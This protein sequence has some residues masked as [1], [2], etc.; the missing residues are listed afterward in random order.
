MLRERTNLVLGRGEVYFDRFN[1]GM[2]S[3]NGE[4]YI[5]NTPSF[6]ITRE[7]QRQSRARSYL[8]KRHEARGVVISETIEIRMTTD[9]MSIENVDMWYSAESQSEN[10]G[11]E[12]VPFTESFPIWRGRYYQLGTS[13]V[14]GGVR[15]VDSLA[16]SVGGTPLVAGADYSFSRDTGRIYIHPSAAITD[17]VT[18]TASYMKRPST[19]GVFSS[20]PQELYGAMRYVGKEVYGPRVDYWFPQVRISPRGAVEMKGDEFRQMSFDVTAIR[21]GPQHALMYG[22]HDGLPPM[23]VTADTVLITADTTQYTADNDRWNREDA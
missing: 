8:G 6:Q 18:A 17:G 9:N 12:F 3:G 11:D 4:R 20:V 15:Y 19:V 22:I 1:T 23:P 10:I 2:F 14:I 5:G 13:E 21:L 16:L 7:V